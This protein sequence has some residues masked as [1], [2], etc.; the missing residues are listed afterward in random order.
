MVEMERAISK[1][2]GLAQRST[3]AITR[4]A[5]KA[6]EVSEDSLRKACNELRR[7]VRET[8]R[9]TQLA[10]QRIAEL[11]E[12]RALL[13]V[14]LDQGGSNVAELRRSEEA[15]WGGAPRTVLLCFAFD[16]ASSRGSG[17]VLL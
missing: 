14:Q 2:E 5:Q 1:R 9:E 13:G 10:E 8:E 3:L 6:P 16:F 12:R 7:S 17:G 11:E 4:V 15:R